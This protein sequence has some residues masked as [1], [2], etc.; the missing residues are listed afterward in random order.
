MLQRDESNCRCCRVDGRGVSAE[1]VAFSNSCV[2]ARCTGRWSLVDDKDTRCIG[3][4]RGGCG[5]AVAVAVVHFFGN[6][7]YAHTC[8][9]TRSTTFTH[10]RAPKSALQKDKWNMAVQIFFKAAPISDTTKRHCIPN[11]QCG[12]SAGVDKAF[13]AA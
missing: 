2:R 13:A 1:S 7:T 11:P 6:L 3:R 9:L 4:F 8:T 5:V 12:D 10:M